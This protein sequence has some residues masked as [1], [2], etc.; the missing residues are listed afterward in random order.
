MSTRNG[1]KTK[2][3]G[4]RLEHL[5]LRSLRLDPQNP[6]LPTAVRGT[7]DQTALARFIAKKYYAIEIARSIATNGYFESEPLIGVKEDSTWR[8]VEGNRRLTALKGLTE[9]GVRKGFSSAKEWE[10]LAKRAKV[11][12]ELPVVVTPREDDIW[13]IVGYRHISGIEPWDPHAKAQFIVSR[14]DAD[15]SWA[16]VAVLVGES[17]TSVRSHYRN[18]MINEQARDDFK[19]DSSEVE[20]NFGTFTRAMGS[21]AIRSFIHA[22]P[23]GEVRKKTKPLPSS[24]RSQTTEL[25][26]WIF[27]ADGQDPVLE[28]SRQLTELAIVLADKRSTDVLRE[29]RDLVEAYLVSPGQRD[30]LAKRLRRADSLLRTTLPEVRASRNDPVIQELV[31]RC[32]KAAKDLTKALN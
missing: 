2:T 13:P 24:R 16:R 1:T 20:S 29:T 8:I 26:S 27:G 28:E 10:S 14:V 18:F 15:L 22:P 21:V 17:E 19:I 7:R 6:R 9:P 3:V 32:V 25:L 4:G 23:P 11:P 5:P 30:D 12:A 31:R